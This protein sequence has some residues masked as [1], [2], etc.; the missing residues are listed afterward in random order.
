MKTF[1]KALANKIATVI[2]LLLVIVGGYTW[3]QQKKSKEIE[4]E[5]SY[6][7][8]RFS[9][10]SE[11]VVADADVQTTAN[12]KFSAD[13]TKDWPK[14]TKT[15]SDI[16][17]SRKVVLEIPVKTEFKLQLEGI[18]NEDIKIEDKVLTFTKPLVV[19][20]DS[21]Q[22]GQAEIKATSSGLIDKA[23]DLV[24]GSKKSMEFLEEKSQD[25]IYNT[26]EEVMNNAERQEKAAGYAEEALENLLNLNSEEKISVKID[27]ADL[28]FENVDPKQ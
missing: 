27:T 20:V 21:Q 23:V 11:L 13:L 22:E 3:L 17:V 12:K 26:S 18:S 25:A 6:V 4:A 9:K 1:G 14:W 8:K 15:F 2:V 5:Y 7:I 28:R 24:T 10:K 16:L 19:N